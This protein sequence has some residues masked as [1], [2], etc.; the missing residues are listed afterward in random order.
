MTQLPFS[1]TLNNDVVMPGFGFGVYQA[2]PD[3]TLTSVGEAIDA[4][5]RLIDTA[6]IY[7]NEREVGEAIVR[8]DVDRDELFVTTKLWIH[9]Y[10]HDAARHAFDASLA[11]LGLDRI[12][13]YLLHW[14]VPGDF[15][16]TIASYKVAEQLLADGQ[17]RAIGVSNFEPDHLDRLMNEAS[18]VPAVNQIELHPYFPQRSL[19]TVHETLGI[20]T[21]AWSPLG[22]VNVYDAKA[23]AQERRLLDDPV[24]QAIAADHGKSTAQVTLRWHVQHGISIIPK[25]VRRERIVENAA[26]FDFALTPEEMTRIDALDSGIRGGPD[27]ETGD[28]VRFPFLVKD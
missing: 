11:K 20:V 13:L 18:V 3:Q 10:G 27:P 6:A 25:S 15:G 26:I 7:G 24:L 22:G 4:G 23:P 12:D 9:D 8:S 19:R 14:P 16:A 28:R 5:Y 1:L 21:Q 17:V 2:P